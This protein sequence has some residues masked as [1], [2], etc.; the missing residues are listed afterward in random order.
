MDEAASMHHTPEDPVP[1]LAGPTSD[2][3]SQ[4]ARGIMYLMQL[5]SELSLRT[6]ATSP[7]YKVTHPIDFNP[8]HWVR[9]IARPCPVRPR[10]GF[11]DSRQVKTWKEVET[12]RR[13]TYEADPDGELLFM[14]M[15]PADVN[16]IIHPGGF[17]LGPGTDGATA[18]RQTV[19]LPV[20]HDY[21]MF[22]RETYGLQP[23]DAPYLELVQVKNK[24]TPFLVQVRAGP[25]IG[26]EPDYVPEAMIVQD[27]VEIDGS[28]D[29][30]EWETRA[31]NMAGSGV[32]VYHP[33]GSL[34]SHFGVHCALNGVPYVTTHRPEI[35]DPLEPVGDAPTWDEEAAAMLARM[36]ASYDL[37]QPTQPGRNWMKPTAIRSMATLHALGSLMRCEHEHALKL[38]AWS[39]TNLPRVL[40][41]MVLGETRHMLDNCNQKSHTMPLLD[42]M[43]GNMY[44]SIR[45]HDRDQVYDAARNLTLPQTRDGLYVAM[46]AFENLGWHGGFGGPRWQEIASRS[47]RF[48]DAVIE[49][50]NERNPQALHRALSHFN[51][52]VNL[53]HNNGWWFNKI[54]EKEFADAVAQMPALGLVSGDVYELLTGDLQLLGDTPHIQLDEKLPAT[55]D[56]TI[57][58]IIQE[59]ADGGE[60]DDEPDQDIKSLTAAK[61]IL[62]LNMVGSKLDGAF[63]AHDPEPYMEPEG[64]KWVG[65]LNFRL[66]NPNGWLFKFQP[67]A[68]VG[69]QIYYGSSSFVPMPMA[70]AEHPSL[71]AWAALVRIAQKHGSFHHDS[72]AEY[73]RMKLAVAHDNDGLPLAVVRLSVPEFVAGGH[74]EPSNDP[75]LDVARYHAIHLP[76]TYPDAP[77]GSPMSLIRDEIV[78]LAPWRQL[79][80]P[81]GTK[82]MA[83]YLGKPIF[84]MLCPGHESEQDAELDLTSKPINWQ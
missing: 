49:L 54:M 72:V 34:A 8:N 69:S 38:T 73:G 45:S 81:G 27:V 51:V 24:D 50:V 29:L 77:Q 75:A 10:H 14:E 18:G 56:N 28:E 80:T 71:P 39:L 33:G 47:L 40:A 31:Q 63:Q 48:T 36:V 16:A 76:P 12:I 44:A 67:K 4:K 42:L 15:I 13:E 55:V 64:S 70:M 79:F 9:T 11:V 3:R 82:A 20:G 65:V 84:H 66:V 68:M 17:V 59:A 60:P 74:L 1:E 35:S 2:V 62:K 30:L 58:N 23:D 43:P 37:H 19:N 41:G 78:L 83:S 6:P 32:V 57:D 53:A 46:Q 22:S 7:I 52:V 21:Q 61:K 26:G 25:M 5:A